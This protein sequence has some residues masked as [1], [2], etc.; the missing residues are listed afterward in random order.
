MFDSFFQHLQW[1]LLKHF[2][3]QEK[4]QF[5]QLIIEAQDV[6]F[7]FTKNIDKK[8]KFY[9]NAGEYLPTSVVD[10]FGAFCTDF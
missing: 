7:N 3:S 10:V 1:I 5:S 4:Q 2:P 6:K 9:L 8:I